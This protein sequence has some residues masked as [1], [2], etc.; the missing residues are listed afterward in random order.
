MFR[1]F[2]CWSSKHRLGSLPDDVWGTQPFKHL[3][4][5]GGC[6]ESH[7][8]LHITVHPG[9]HL[10]TMLVLASIPAACRTLASIQ[11]MVSVV[12]TGIESY[13]RKHSS[14]N[15]IDSG[16]NADGGWGHIVPSVAVP[17]LAQDEFVNGWCY[18][19]LLIC[20]FCF[21]WSRKVNWV[22]PTG[23]RTNVLCKIKGRLPTVIGP[24]GSISVG[25]R[26][27]TKGLGVLNPHENDRKWTFS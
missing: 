11:F 23:G 9:I 16:A 8:T 10:Y 20:F 22:T 13:F 3:L 27:Q 6:I 2:R 19:R 12:E 1:S 17:E 15:S 21:F 26:V 4:S 25:Q 14:S 24:S 7:V 18:F 5:Y